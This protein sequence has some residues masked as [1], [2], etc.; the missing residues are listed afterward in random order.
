MHGWRHCQIT[1][2]RNVALYKEMAERK[3][4]EAKILKAM[5]SLEALIQHNES[6]IK[7]WSDN[8]YDLNL[9][10]QMTKFLFLHF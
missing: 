7:T 4:I 8:E 10:M 3:T 6:D 2:K 9:H 1:T 5:D